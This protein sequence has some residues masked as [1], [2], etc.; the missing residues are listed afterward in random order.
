MKKINYTGSSKIIK[1][2]CDN[3]NELIEGG[4]GGGSNV[5]ITPSLT[6]GVKI[7][8]YEIDGV[9]GALYAPSYDDYDNQGF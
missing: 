4:G 1:H 6:S 8:D 5:T 9:D 3:V 7:A 2:I